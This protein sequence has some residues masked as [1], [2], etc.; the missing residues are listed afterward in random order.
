MTKTSASTIR[1][2]LLVTGLLT[3]AATSL[4]A[5]NATRGAGEDVSAIGHTTSDAAS[6]TQQ[7][8]AN[9]TGAPT[10]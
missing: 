10:R 6:A 5:C 2:L 4:S 8:V 1:R 3:A 9:A 7:G